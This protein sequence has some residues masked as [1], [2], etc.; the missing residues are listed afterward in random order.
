MSC[1]LTASV[2]VSP[3]VPMTGPNNSHAGIWPP[4]ACTLLCGPK[5]AMLINTP[6]TTASTSA[7]ADWIDTQLGRRAILAVYISHGLGDFFYGLPT[8]RKRFPGIKTYCTASTLETMT[9]N[10]EVEAFEAFASQFPGQ[11]DRQP[12]PEYLAEPLLEGNRMDLD[13]YELQAIPVGHAAVPD[14]TIVWV[15]SLRLAICGAVVYGDG[16]LMMINCPTKALRQAWISS[17][18]RVEEL[19]PTSVVCGHQK[20]GEVAGLWH[21]QRNRDYIETFDALLESGRA[22]TAEE[23]VSIMM[24]MYPERFN[25]GALVLSTKAAF[26]DAVTT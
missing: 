6:F 23:F 18:Q 22:K 26:S 19:D 4:I 11:I 9:A 2:F 15:P 3:P 12:A 25:V 14:S 16:H 8:L 1:K 24:E 20:P 10:V 5:S 21:L 7:L 13:G 17:I